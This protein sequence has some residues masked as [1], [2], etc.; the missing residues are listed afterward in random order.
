ML[1]GKGDG[2]RGPL[3]CRELQADESLFRQTE[4]LLMEPPT[5]APQEEAMDQAVLDMLG[6]LGKELV[7]GTLS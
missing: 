6:V 5:E 2:S 7:G 1:L 3:V 4:Q